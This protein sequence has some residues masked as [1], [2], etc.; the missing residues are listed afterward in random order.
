MLRLQ[1]LGAVL[2]DSWSTLLKL[3]HR[4][5]DL[6]EKYGGPIAVFL[7]IV[8]LT[9][10]GIPTARDVLQFWDNIEQKERAQVGIILLQTVATLV[11]GIAIFW[12]IVLARKQMKL[13]QDQSKNAQ[14]QIKLAQNQII[15]E[16]FSRSV[17]QLGHDQSSVR[18]GAIYSLERV[19]R[20]S[21]QDHSVVMEVVASYIRDQSHIVNGEDISQ[22][23]YPGRDIHAAITVLDRL[24]LIENAPCICLINV[25]LRGVD[26]ANKKF[27]N[28]DLA[29]SNLSGYETNLFHVSLRNANCYRTNLSGTQLKQADLSGARIEQA[30]LSEARMK[31]CNL[32]EADLRKADLRGAK[33]L[34]VSQIQKAKNWQE[35]IYDPD[36]AELLGLRVRES[37]G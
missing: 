21:A 31:D 10:I 2:F 32:A 9:A 24:N 14:D 34:T 7:A 13:A 33:Y 35:A 30:N 29:R 1:K 23:P 26:F 8:L 22:R 15:T 19:A 37:R 27:N 25:D 3:W 17:E 6:E 20:D 18:M 5:E 12:N 16:L 11:G 28:S 36:F 4:A